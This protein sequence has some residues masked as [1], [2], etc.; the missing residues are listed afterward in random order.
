VIWNAC[1]FLAVLLVG[2]CIG[3]AISFVILESMICDERKPLSE[4]STEDLVS[5]LTVR[6]LAP[7]GAA[8]P[9]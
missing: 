6:G 3:V 2:I 5:E 7:G 8:K 4:R 9:I 1:V